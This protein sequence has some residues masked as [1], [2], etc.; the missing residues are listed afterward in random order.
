MVR[1]IDGDTLELEIDLG[2]GIHKIDRF[3]VYGINTAELIEGLREIYRCHGEDKN[4][5]DICNRLIEKYGRSI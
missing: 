2:F 3:R 5:A 1:V 4:I